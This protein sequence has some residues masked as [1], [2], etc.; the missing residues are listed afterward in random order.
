M[1]MLAGVGFYSYTVGSLT[2]FL[3]GYDTRNNIL[4]NKLNTLNKIAVESNIEFEFKST[5]TGSVKHA[6]SRSNFSNQDKVDLLNDLPKDLKYQLALTMNNYVASKFEFFKDR[7]P[8]FI[9]VTIPC[10]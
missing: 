4:G 7:E 3:A 8:S 10:R 1:W 6:A 5:L 2:S 9:T